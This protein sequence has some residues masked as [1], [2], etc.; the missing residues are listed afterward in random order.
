[1]AYPIST[2]A[3]RVQAALHAHG[4][5]CQVV[6]LPDSTRSAREAAQAIAIV[7]DFIVASIIFVP[8][9]PNKNTSFRISFT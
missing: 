5:R 9:T 1:M 2:S 6:E 8:H 3:Q 7:N 4:V